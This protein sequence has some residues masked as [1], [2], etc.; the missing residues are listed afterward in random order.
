M[1]I[2]CTLPLS[3]NYVRKDDQYEPLHLKRMVFR[4]INSAKNA[5]WPFVTEM[6]KEGTS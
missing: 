3:L 2:K 1:Q 5:E 6:N 4:I